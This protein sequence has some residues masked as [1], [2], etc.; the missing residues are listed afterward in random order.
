MFVPGTE[1]IWKNFVNSLYD[2][3]YSAI[4]KE[5]NDEEIND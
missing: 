4:N 5:I 3:N 1:D 2:Y